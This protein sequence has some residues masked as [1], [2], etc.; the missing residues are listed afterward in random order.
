MK[1]EE[2][3]SILSKLKIPTGLVFTPTN[4][5]IEKKKFFASDTYEPQ[6]VYKV[7]RNSNSDILKSLLHVREISDVDPR[8]SDFYINLIESKKLS[9][10]LMYSVGDNDL[11][12]EI[13]YRK[14]GKPSALLFRNSARVLR[15][16]VDNYNIVKY[17]V[18]NKDD[19]LNFEQIKEIFEIVFKSF[20]LDD[21]K[22]DKSIRIAKNGAKV[23]TKSKTVL[24]DENIH[25]SKFKL[26]K[27]L[28]HEVGTH[29]L[30]SINGTNSGFEA[31]S[32]ANLPSYLD[33]EEGL[34]TWNES[35]MDLLTLRWLKEKAAMVWGAYIG[36]ELSFRELYNCMLGVLPKRSAFG[37]V[38]RLKRGLGDTSYPGLYA[39]DIVYFRGFRK[40]LRELEKD[41]S[42]YEKLYAGKIGF[43]QCEWVD[44]GLIPKA[45]IIPSKDMWRGIFKRVGI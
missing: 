8:I 25:R 34:A 39:K 22:V 30:R 26:R 9:N 12:T 43:E 2:V 21:W 23:A 31:L 44:E 3:T 18:I 33:V 17:P 27:T 19:M 1:L 36:E 42:M 28:V 24:L 5:E 45:K 29:V 4:L 10:D 40:V 14:Y 41:K 16:V 11:V 35:D 20:G 37:V 32:K 38:Y 13:S 7:V 15:G 6:F